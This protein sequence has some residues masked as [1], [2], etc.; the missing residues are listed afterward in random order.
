MCKVETLMK[1]LKIVHNNG[2]GMSR[3]N[4]QILCG[5]DDKNYFQYLDRLLE[6]GYIRE[7]RGSQSYRDYVV[8]SP[9]AIVLFNDS[10]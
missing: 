9:E 3:E 1:I 2:N 10:A 4:L 7:G 8:L 5:L 6:L